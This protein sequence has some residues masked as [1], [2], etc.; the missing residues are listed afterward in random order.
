MWREC[1]EVFLYA[2]DKA[3]HK[4]DFALYAVCIMSNHWISRYSWT[5]QGIDN[6]CN[7]SYCNLCYNKRLP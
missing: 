2:I 5:H 7:N 1:C 6:Y 3:L 4:F